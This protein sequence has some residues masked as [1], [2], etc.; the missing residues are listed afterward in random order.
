MAYT[1]IYRGNTPGRRREKR[2]RTSKEEP[3]LNGYMSREH[4]AL[5]RLLPLNVTG[6]QQTVF[7]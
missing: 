3:A 4:C 5:E 2:L 6:S 1:P 7:F